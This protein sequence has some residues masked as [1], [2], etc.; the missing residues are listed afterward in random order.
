MIFTHYK[1]TTLWNNGVILY[2]LHLHYT[3]W[4]KKSL[5]QILPGIFLYKNKRTIV[6]N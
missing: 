4:K 3:H 1:I 6:V 2:T 5:P